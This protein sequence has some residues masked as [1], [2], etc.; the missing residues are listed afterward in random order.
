MG[1]LEA[2]A[3]RWPRLA[4]DD[5]F[6]KLTSLEKALPKNESL[7]DLWG[8]N[9]AGILPSSRALAGLKCLS[10]FRFEIEIEELTF[11]AEEKPKT[12]NA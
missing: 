12:V 8:R 9:H 3:D 2:V 4:G 6:V 11:R 1:N 5:A 7:D 10:C